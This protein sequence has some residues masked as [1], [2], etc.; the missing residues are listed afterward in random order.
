MSRHLDN[1]KRLFQKLQVRYGAD[2]EMV[3]EVKKEL[4]SVEAIESGYQDLTIRYRE[5]LPG[6]A[7]APHWD[8]V[9]RHTTQPISPQ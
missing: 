1:L 7:S 3:L 9:A 8:A 4:D 6:Q 5:S 2:S